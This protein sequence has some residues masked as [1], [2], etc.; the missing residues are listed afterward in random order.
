V[1]VLSYVAMKLSGFPPNRVIGLGTFLDSCRLQHYIS[2]ELGLSPSSVQSLVIGESGPTSG[3][4]RSRATHRLVPFFLLP[5]PS[6][7]QPLPLHLPHPLPPA[8]DP[9]S[10]WPHR[11]LSPQRRA[12]FVFITVITAERTIR[13]H[14]IPSVTPRLFPFVSNDFS[15]TGMLNILPPRDNVTR[16]IT[17]NSHS[18]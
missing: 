11:F 13:A 7:S 18:L 1:D 17:R 5:P 3:I 2:K 14:S 6:L 15:L 16:A 8:I 10:T 4:A 12:D 9:H